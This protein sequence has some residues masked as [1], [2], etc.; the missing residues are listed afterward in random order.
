MMTHAPNYWLT[1]GSFVPGE[2]SAPRTG[3]FEWLLRKLQRA[4]C[5]LHGHDA[6]LQYEHTRIFLRCMS[7]GY[8]TPGWDVSP[9]APPPR[10]VA[11]V[12]RAR[13]APAGL[14]HLRKIA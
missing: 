9:G 12:R 8:E 2:A 14:T 13:P 5:S 6:I 10:R 7:C 4:V 11:E 3:P 1:R